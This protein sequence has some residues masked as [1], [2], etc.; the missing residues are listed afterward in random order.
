MVDLGRTPVY[1]GGDE[2]H[3]AVVGHSV[4]TTGRNL[5]G[6]FLPLF[7]SLSDPTADL[8]P[9]PWGNTW[10][11]PF[12]FYLVAAVLTVAP[13][14][15]F[16]VRLPVAI[17]G[18]VVT[19][20]LL[21]FVA[22]RLFKKRAL[23]LGCAAL[24]A[25]MPPQL[26]L[27]RQALDYVCPLPFILAWFWFLIDYAETR[28]LRSLAWGGLCLGVGFYSYIASWVMMKPSAYMTWV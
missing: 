4:A 23:A 6:D 18:G 22:L 12:L 9:M 2:A 7:F 28:R 26:I 24:F 21:Y 10:Y 20:V 13:P 25:L 8:Q 17:I 16:V 5:N 14:G 27:S 11:Q 19:P 3:F 15:E 1:F